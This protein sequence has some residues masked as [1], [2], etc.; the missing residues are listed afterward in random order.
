MIYLTV[1]LHICVIFICLSFFAYF[2]RVSFVEAL[3]VLVCVLALVLY[4]LAMIRHLLWIEGIEALVVIV[5]AMWFARKTKEARKD[6]LKNCCEN[7]THPSFIA[8]VLLLLVVALCTSGKVVTWWD[9][10]N[11][12]AADAKALYYL[13]GFAG[14]Y[15]AEILMTLKF[16]QDPLSVINLPGKYSSSFL[17]YQ[18][19]I[20]R[21]DCAR[22]QLVL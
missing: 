20:H 6:Y 12:W 22:F 19:L 10:I 18:S 16:P 11:F 2:F 13:D 8:A 1:F 21:P 9:D 17:E 3:P 4:A 7:M 14:K 5:F 15:G